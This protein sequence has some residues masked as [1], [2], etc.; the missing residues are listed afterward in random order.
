MTLAT[1][2]TDLMK[3]L[4]RL[5][6]LNVDGFT[7]QADSFTPILE[8]CRT[9]AS[10]SRSRLRWA[11][12]QCNGISRYDAKVGRAL[13]SWT[14]AD[15]DKADAA[16]EKAAQRIQAALAVIY[17]PTWAERMA[18]ELQN[19]PRGAMVKLFTRGEEASGNARAYA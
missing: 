5:H 11:E 16:D 8:A 6:E 17:G 7:M 18:L 13:A 14:D 3:T 1:E 9:I 2:T 10:A 19:D 4:Y 12:K 15:Q